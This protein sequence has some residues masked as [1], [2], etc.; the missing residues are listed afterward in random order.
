MDT[1]N[2]GI[3]VFN[4]LIDQMIKLSKITDNEIDQEII[5]KNFTDLV[6]QDN[7]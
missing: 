3:L 6:D 2:Q 5:K 7:M 4:Q 1:V